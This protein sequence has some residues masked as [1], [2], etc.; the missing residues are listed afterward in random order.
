[1][2]D[3]LNKDGKEMLKERDRIKEANGI[4]FIVNV[5]NEQGYRMR[6]CLGLF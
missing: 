6:D 4:I 3:V 5:L 1:M 2:L